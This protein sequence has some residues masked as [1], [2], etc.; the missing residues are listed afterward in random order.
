M[1]QQSP[2]GTQA[3]SQHHRLLPSAHATDHAASVATK[4]PF[5]NEEWIAHLDTARLRP[6]HL[7][8]ASMNSAY[9]KGFTITELMITVAI[10]AILMAVAVPSFTELI[11]R[12]RLASASNDL[13]A[14]LMYARSEAV[15][16]NGIVSVCRVAAAGSDVC[17]A[18][19]NWDRW[20]V[21]T[22]P[23][24]V[25]TNATRRRGEID[26]P[27]AIRTAAAWNGRIDFGSAGRLD[28]AMAANTIRL[29]S[30]AI[31]TDNVRTFSFNIAGRATVQTTTGACP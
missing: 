4:A 7:G 6:E 2:A 10:M 22:D 8:M 27:V 19:G 29:C 16:T 21:T 5:I 31:N 9:H 12:S 1:R 18:N 13:L 15:R 26:N 17:V 23:T 30:A 14:S 3:G 25:A 20:I 11:A 24:G 28:V